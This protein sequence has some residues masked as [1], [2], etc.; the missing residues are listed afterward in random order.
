[1][2]L[3]LGFSGLV[4]DGGCDGSIEGVSAGVIAISTSTS[5][6]GSIQIRSNEFGRTPEK[7]KGGNPAG[8]AL[9]D[10]VVGHVGQQFL[11]G[12]VLRSI[13]VQFVQSFESIFRRVFMFVMVM[14]MMVIVSSGRG[15]IGSGG[16]FVADD[17]DE[18][19]VDDLF[20]R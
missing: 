16:E 9:E 8:R 19:V 14:V 7:E 11:F 20:F 13:V 15:G 5:T 12:L 6:F 17:G 2:G 18:S 4:D 10:S 3:G 1:M